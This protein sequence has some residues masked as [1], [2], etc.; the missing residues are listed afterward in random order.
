MPR[1]VLALFRGSTEAFSAVVTAVG[2]VLGVD[3][4]DVP[5]ET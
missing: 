4:Y 5:F 3:G 1:N 2:I